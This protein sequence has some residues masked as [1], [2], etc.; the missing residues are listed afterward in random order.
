MVIIDDIYNVILTVI[1]QQKCGF[2]GNLM[3]YNEIY[4]NQQK[5]GIS[6]SHLRV[7]DEEVMAPFASMI[8][9]A[10]QWW[11][12]SS[13][14][15]KFPGGIRNRHESIMKTN[16]VQFLRKERHSRII[17]Q[18]HLVKKKK[19]IAVNDFPRRHQGFSGRLLECR[20]I[21]SKN[22]TSDITATF[23]ISKNGTLYRDGDKKCGFLTW[24]GS[25]D[26]VGY[27][28]YPL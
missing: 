15:L 8:S 23:W 4:C 9:C 13:Q 21:T 12:C 27:V 6:L 7:C 24:T 22:Q 16:Y 2:L 26:I 5:M 20:Q 19:K 28:P 3:R 10:S 14:T 18:S 25:D 1:Q 17:L 11:R